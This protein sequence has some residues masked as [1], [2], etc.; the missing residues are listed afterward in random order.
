[1]PSSAFVQWLEARAEKSSHGDVAVIALYLRYSEKLSA[2]DI[3]VSIIIQ[4]VQWSDRLPD[5]TA[6]VRDAFKQRGPRRSGRPSFDILV[7]LMK[8]IINIYREVDIIIDGIDEM[9]EEIQW[10]I[11]DITTSTEARVLFTSRSI[12]TLEGRLKDLKGEDVTFLDFVASSEDLDLF[13]GGVIDQSPVLA[14][15]LKANNAK[16]DVMTAIKNKADGM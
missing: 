10:L 4:L 12:R 15:L 9:P 5:V 8:F 1:M 14:A 3:I 13:I 6:V 16:E 7:Q 11:I 2:W